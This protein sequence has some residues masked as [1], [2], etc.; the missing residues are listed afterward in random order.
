[1]TLQDP[2]EA[3]A[4]APATSQCRTLLFT[5][6]VSRREDILHLP[7]DNSRIGKKKPF[8]K[9]QSHTTPLSLKAEQN[10]PTHRHQCQCFETGKPSIHASSRAPR[11]SLTPPHAG[12][13]DGPIC[14]TQ[15]KHSRSWFSMHVL[16]LSTLLYL[17]VCLTHPSTPSSSAYGGQTNHT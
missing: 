4:A 6:H 5:L 15:T 17:S 2:S 8:S 14:P 16:I 13:P 12:G 1:M 7:L 10:P 11:H 3:S 9:Q